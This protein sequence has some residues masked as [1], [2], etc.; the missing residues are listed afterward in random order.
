CHIC[1]DPL[2]E[3]QLARQLPCQHTFHQ[4]CIDKWLV[5]FSSRC[6]LCKFNCD[7]Y[8]ASLE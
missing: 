8:C 5:Q 4:E 6:P 2:T 3:G 1:L 7:P